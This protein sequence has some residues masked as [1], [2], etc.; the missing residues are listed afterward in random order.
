MTD[1]NRLERTWMR[2]VI[3]A[4]S[5]FTL[6]IAFIASTRLQT[7]FA[8]NVPGR[9]MTQWLIVIQGLLAGP[10]TCSKGLKEGTLIARAEAHL[11]VGLGHNRGEHLEQAPHTSR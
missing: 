3:I 10:R 2:F 5:A 11:H 1:E 4:L 6:A 7:A 9:E 8:S